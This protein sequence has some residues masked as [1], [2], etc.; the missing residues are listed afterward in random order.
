MVGTLFGAGKSLVESDRVWLS[1]VESRRKKM[2]VEDA[3]QLGVASSCT[4]TKIVV[5]PAKINQGREG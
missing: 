3:A 1:V 5:V 2:Q 4:I